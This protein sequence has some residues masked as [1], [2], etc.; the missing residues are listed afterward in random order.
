MK[1]RLSATCL[2][3]IALS[4]TLYASILPTFHLE[5]G[6]LKTFENYV[7]QFE[8]NVADPFEQSGKTWADGTSCCARNSALANGKPVVEPRENADIAG[9]S[10]HHF[11]GVIYIKGATIAD[12]KHIMQDYSNYPKYF[13]PDVSKG[14]GSIGPD[15]TPADEHFTS[16]MSLIQQTLW[17][18]VSYD[19]IYETHYRLLDPHRWESKSTSASIKEWRDPRDVSRGYYPEGDDHG[20]LWRTNTYWFVREGTG[21]VNVELD[22]MTLSRPIPAGFAWWG[23]KRT[24]DAVDKMLRDVKVAVD[25]LHS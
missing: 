23:S 8:R 2:A 15:S 11:S 21:G 4:T 24:K 22:S 25:A 6:A 12:V 3:G 9:G 13:K 18:A 14:S 10:I 16:Q 7:A 20:F 17:I 19:C 5:P 1:L